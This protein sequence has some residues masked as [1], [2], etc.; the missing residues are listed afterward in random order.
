MCSKHQHSNDQA[1]TAA[2]G[3]GLSVRVDDMTCGHCAGTIK[4]AIESSI[5][6]AKVTADPQAK[7]VSVEGASDLAQISSII[8]LA[9]YTP[10]PALS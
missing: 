5:P 4:S 2:T 7:L 10:A 8:T 9:G 3:A 6:G 1:S